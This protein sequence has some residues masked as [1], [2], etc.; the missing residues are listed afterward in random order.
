MNTIKTYSLGGFRV[1]NLSIIIK[2]SGE[3]L[4]NYIR[5]ISPLLEDEDTELIIINSLGKVTDVECSYTLYSFSES[6]RNFKDFCFA[7]SNGKRVV[8]IED[9]MVITPDIVDKIEGFSKD[10]Q[11]LNLLCSY[12]IYLNHDR[13]IYFVHSEELVHKRGLKGFNTE[14]ETIIEDLSFVEAAENDIETCIERLIKYGYCK[15]LYLWFEN[16]IFNKSQRFQN[17]FCEILEKKKT[18]MDSDDVKYLDNLFLNMPHECR[19]KKYIETRMLFKEKKYLNINEVL[20]KIKNGNFNQETLY[21]SW[22]LNDTFD[23]VKYIFEILSC[24]DEDNLCKYLSYLFNNSQY[25]SNQIYDFIL[26]TPLLSLDDSKFSLFLNV[27]KDYVIF[28]SNSPRMPDIKDKLLNVFDK[29]IKTSL[30][31]CDYLEKE[32]ADFVNEV[33]KANAYIEENKFE[34]AIDILNPL[35]K[36]SPTFS[37]A[38]LHYIQSI[39]YQ[40]NCY[41]YVLSIC[42]IVKNEEKNIQRCLS[43]LVPL[44]DS[45]IAELII[46]DTGSTDNTIKISK[47]FTDKVYS[48]SWQGNFSEARNYSIS[49]ANGEYILILDADEEFKEN[50]ILKLVEEFSN[51]QYKPFNTFSFKLINYT[52]A[53]LQEYAVLTQPRIFKNDGK[54][55]YSSSVHNQPTFS[56][57]AK[58]LDIFIHHYGYIMTE[59]IRERKFQRTAT[60]LKKELEKDPKNIYYRF[61]LSTSYAMYGDEGEALK[62]VEIYMRHIK[63][64]GIVEEN[65]LMYLNNAASIYIS[66]SLHDKALDI[67]D[68]ALSIKPDFID[69]IFYKLFILYSKQEYKEA[70]EYINRYLNIIDDFYTMDISH[71]G[72]FSFYSLGLKDDVLRMMALSNYFEGKYEE[73]INGTLEIKNEFTLKNC[74]YAF[75]DSCFKLK[76]FKDLSFF[77]IDRMLPT[78]K[79]DFKGVFNFFLINNLFKYGKEA[80]EKCI[81]TFE[82]S[83]VDKDFTADIKLRY[84]NNEFPNEGE[85]IFLVDNYDL[86][87]LDISSAVSIFN[88]LLSNFEEFIPLETGDIM[89]ACSYKQFAQFVLHRALEIKYF[90]NYYPDKLLCILKKYIDLCSYITSK[91]RNELLTSKENHF[92]LLISSALREFSLGNIDE[93]IRLSKSSTSLYKKMKGIVSLLVETLVPENNQYQESSIYELE[94]NKYAL[95]LKEE[96]SK[97]SVENS[98]ENI[99]E[100]FSKYDREDL[101]DSQLFSFKAIVLMGDNRF[102]E[103]ESTL[104]RGLKKYPTDVTLLYN[105]ARLHSFSLNNKEAVKYYIMSKLLSMELKQ[106]FNFENLAIEEPLNKN[107][108]KVLIGTLDL[109]DKIVTLSSGLKKRG[110]YARSINYYPGNKNYNSD[111]IVDVNIMD[112]G[113]DILINSTET[114]AKLIS[115]YNVFHF[116]FGTSLT[117]HHND[118]ALLK[119]FNKGIVMHFWGNDARIYSKA[120]KLNP[121]ITSKNTK[122]DVIK[123]NLEFYSRYTSNCIATDYEVYEYLKDFFSNVHV[124]PSPIDLEKY[125]PSFPKARDG[126]ITIVH[127]PSSSEAKGT[128][129]IIKA[130]NELQLNYD[131]EFKI[132]QGIPHDQAIKIYRD[133][134]LIID[135]V[136]LGSYGQLAIE[137]MALGKPVICY[138]SDF[139]KDKY[140]LELPIISANPDNIKDI[141][142]YALKNRDMLCDAGKMGRSYVEKYHDIN[143]IASILINL[144]RKVLKS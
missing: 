33:Y 67:C 19:Y 16:V 20:E 32:D 64:L 23:S 105:M 113:L 52:D 73:C 68:N 31:F 18:E 125:K 25:F 72:R 111:Y 130:I 4:K 13:S 134:D 8:I 53:L 3:K 41:P 21:F 86:D 116:N 28:I 55:Y 47:S 1:K 135:Q 138:I 36:M 2:S 27:I 99:F 78:Q 108:L 117:F 56:P 137:A 92:L 7:S 46:V 58:N 143:N 139:M 49:L 109:T 82:D 110:I 94:E 11:N 50:N 107:A 65:H 48:K 131:I 106:K 77:Y 115:E 112:S 118:L 59:E 100:I 96:L 89:Q 70:L 102:N 129:Y 81:L 128:K 5:T 83:K 6:Y 17:K 84:E 22:F 24:I 140:P 124:I 45:K 14:K 30:K 123:R 93:F 44:L 66:N 91:K 38:I 69:F 119:E 103:A 122:D 126:K 9:G 132:L 80:C 63:E 54:F 101:Y 98:I 114:A 62:H 79:N 127:A 26:D 71:D 75:V 136:I 85:L 88:K 141:I 51:I 104:K 37:Y 87:N 15:E 57:P 121:Y 42:M 12:K 90:K 34:E 97:K 133:A 10:T 29:Y 35:V 74:I 40:Y 39:R 144:Y 60:L 120:S 76:D 43:S 61:Q 142:E 95:N